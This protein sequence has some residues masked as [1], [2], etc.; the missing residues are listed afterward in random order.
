MQNRARRPAG[1]LGPGI[2]RRLSAA[3]LGWGLVL[4]AAQPLRAATPAAPDPGVVQQAKNLI[5]WGRAKKARS[6][7]QAAVQQPANRDNARLVAYYGH[8]VMQFG[9]LRDGLKLTKRAVALDPNCASCHLYR[10][11]ALAKRAKTVNHFRALMALPKLRKQLELAD[12]LNPGLGDVQWGWI[13]FDLALPAAVGGGFDNARQ[14]AQLLRRIDPVDGRLAQAQIA[15]AAGQPQAALAAY[16]AAALHHPQDPRG[17]FALGRA[18][19]R[20]G[21]HAAAARYLGAALAL[22]R[23]S[24]LYSAYMA[25]NLVYLRQ[26]EQ[27]RLVL[28]AGD[29]VHPDSRLGE[30]LVARALQAVGQDFPW[31]RQLLAFYL[32]VPPEPGQPSSRQAQRLLAMVDPAA[33]QPVASQHGG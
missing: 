7:L 9:D 10:F 5:E 30:F 17:L 23:Q 22:N 12:K 21:Q 29:Q 19:F 28:Q 8:V 25:A 6:L 16:R 33:S 32:R 31:A 18:L 13:R 20:E 2:L 4:V 26:L 24:A 27:A 15:E 1:R 14:H 11:E 3:V